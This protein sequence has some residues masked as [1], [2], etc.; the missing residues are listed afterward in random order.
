MHNGQEL[1]GHT[2]LPVHR[3]GHSKMSDNKHVQGKV[4]KNR[5]KKKTLASQLYMV[6]DTYAPSKLTRLI[7]TSTARCAPKR[8]REPYGK[9]RA[10]NRHLLKETGILDS[11]F[12]ICGTRWGST[13][14]LTVIVSRTHHFAD[15]KPDQIRSVKITQPE[16]QFFDFASSQRVSVSTSHVR[17]IA[18]R[19]GAGARYIVRQGSSWPS[20]GCCTSTCARYAPVTYVAAGT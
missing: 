17:S 9:N 8:E 14:V 4:K 1:E 7:Q 2:L 12:R 11:P 5:G 10:E 18:R 15:S 3:A 20:W 19:S 16:A 13:V 6:I